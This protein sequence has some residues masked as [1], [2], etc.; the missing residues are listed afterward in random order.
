[1]QAPAS[2]VSSVLS[3]LDHST[4][5]RLSLL[6]SSAW[7]RLSESLLQKY[8]ESSFIYIPVDALSTI[9]IYHADNLNVEP[10]RTD[11]IFIT[12]RRNEFAKPFKGVPNTPETRKTLIK[13]SK[14][15]RKLS[16]Q[17]FQLAKSNLKFLKQL[18][19]H[20][21]TALELH[22]VTYEDPDL[23][24]ELLLE[25]VTKGSPAVTFSTG[26][27]LPSN[28]GDLLEHLYERNVLNGTFTKPLPISPDVIP[29]L[30]ALY[31]KFQRPL[32][33]SLRDSLPLHQGIPGLKDFTASTDSERIIYRST[34]MGHQLKIERLVKEGVI[35]V[36]LE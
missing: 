14:S 32:Q 30:V 18:M 11:A 8:A 19:G 5:S 7:Q 10:L 15:A 6:T 1:M 33:L 26:T 17:N 28:F 25:M 23:F 34:T 12:S 36:N 4:L 20:R 35:H 13:L 29:R 24:N 31:K 16:L 21:F 2:F 9:L 27:T 22:K 3:L